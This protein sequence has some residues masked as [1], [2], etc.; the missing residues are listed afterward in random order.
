M[1]SPRLFSFFFLFLLQHANAAD[2]TFKFFNS[3]SDNQSLP[4]LLISKPDESIMV[5]GNTDGSILLRSIDDGSFIRTI[6]V[7]SRAVNYLNFNSTGRLLISASSNGEIKI[8]DFLKDKV[9]HQ[10]N[11]PQY[12]GVSFSLFSIADGFIYFNGRG[13]LYK[14]RSDLTQEVQ[15]I[16]DFSDSITSG[17]ITDDRNALIISLGKYIYVINTRT[18]EIIQQLYAGNTQVEKLYLVPGS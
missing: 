10:L 1:I 13:R 8:F 18:D 15:K 4:T 11:S 9:I 6:T 12:E 16:Y 2:P 7:H 17:V 3:I 5:Q 14:T